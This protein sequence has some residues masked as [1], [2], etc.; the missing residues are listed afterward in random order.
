MFFGDDLIGPFD[1][2]V[3]DGP[4]PCIDGK[5]PGRVDVAAGHKSDCGD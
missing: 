1:P 4:E 5:F 2:V 3:R